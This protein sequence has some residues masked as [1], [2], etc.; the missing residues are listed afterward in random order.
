MLSVN[1]ES[2]KRIP[3]GRTHT[4]FLP[5]PEQLEAKLLMSID[6]GGTSPTTPP[7]IASAPFGMDFGGATQNQGAGF[8]VADVGDVNGTGYDDFV[9]GAPTVSSSSGPGTIGS[10]VG[11]EVF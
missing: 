11:S 3:E 6:L 8:S 7:L 4:N 9:I 1:R 10:G 5:R 2:R